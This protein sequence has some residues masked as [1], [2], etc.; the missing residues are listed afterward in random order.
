[1]SGVYIEKLGA[2]MQTMNDI[3]IH[4]V[5]SNGG[6]FLLSNLRVRGRN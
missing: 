3:C 4:K 6:S 5:D 1:M 2:T